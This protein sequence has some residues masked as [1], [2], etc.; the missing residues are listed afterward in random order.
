MAQDNKSE[1]LLKQNGIFSRIKSTKH[2]NV[3]Y[4]YIKY[5]IKKVV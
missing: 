3:K 4:Y 5:T 1:I 2:I